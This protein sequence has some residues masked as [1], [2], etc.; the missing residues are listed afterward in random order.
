M[1]YFN[2]DPTK[3]PDFVYDQG[4]EVGLKDGIRQERERIREALL[5]EEALNVATSESA[6]RF[7]EHYR[8]STIPMMEIHVRA[9]VEAALDHIGLGEEAEHG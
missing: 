1:S 9:V 7:P 5:S 8:N 3:A 6:R 4:Y 2:F